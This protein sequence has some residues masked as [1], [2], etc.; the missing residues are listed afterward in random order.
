MSLYYFLSACNWLEK[1]LIV[2]QLVE[3]NYQYNTTSLHD[4]TKQ[5]DLHLSLC[6]YNPHVIICDD[7]KGVSIKLSDR[8]KIS[9]APKNK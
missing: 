1:L 2:S 4:S 6:I 7:K 5:A 3:K 8:C 9:E